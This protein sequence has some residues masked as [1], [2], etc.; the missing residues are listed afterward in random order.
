MKKELYVKENGI[1]THIQRDI[2]INDMY[3][4]NYFSKVFN[5]EKKNYTKEQIE[6]IKYAIYKMLQSVSNRTIENQIL[7]NL[8][9]LIM[10]AK[11]DEDYLEVISLLS[12][13]YDAII[14]DRML[15]KSKFGKSNSSKI[16][17]I[18]KVT[19]FSSHLRNEPELVLS[20]AIKKIVSS[21]YY[22]ILT[23]IDK[24]TL[25]KLMSMKKNN[26]DINN[27]LSI[28]NL[29][30]PEDC[31]DEIAQFYK[32]VFIDTLDDAY[33]MIQVHLC[34]ENCKNARADSCPKIENIVKKNIEEYGFITDGYQ[35][36]DENGNVD[37]FIVTG[38]EK[39]TKE[40]PRKLDFRKVVK[41]KKDLIVN[42]YGTETFQ[43]TPL[44]KELYNSKNDSSKGKTL[45][46]K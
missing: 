41:L 1:T 34:W 13:G 5:I 27:L 14:D 7:S 2:L 15:L 39:Y 25:I 35:I 6:E 45:H 42:Y 28:L 30:I 12:E 46:K 23:S 8:N 36:Y 31:N 3:L 40:P 38:C 29:N 17:N 22:N 20:I 10:H 19:N 32:G 33:D 24:K 26:E 21:Y 18:R 43:D 44:Y 11:S 9:K 16:E 4:I 37:Q